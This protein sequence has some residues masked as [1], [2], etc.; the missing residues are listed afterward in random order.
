[1][2]T[3]DESNHLAALAAKYRAD[4]QHAHSIN[5]PNAQPGIKGMLARAL[6]PRQLKKRGVPRSFP[7]PRGEVFISGPLPQPRIAHAPIGLFILKVY[8]IKLCG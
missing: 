1:M 6:A 2:R 5:E 8:M 4:D 7:R 3:A